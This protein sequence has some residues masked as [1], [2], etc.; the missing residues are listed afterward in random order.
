MCLSKLLFSMTLDS[1]LKNFI[2]SFPDLMSIVFLPSEAVVLHFSLF[3]PNLE[4]NIFS[5]ADCKK[6]IIKY[7]FKIFLIFIIHISQEQS[8]L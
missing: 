3:S 5:I 8:G 4:V 2:C 1:Y 6:L 7:T